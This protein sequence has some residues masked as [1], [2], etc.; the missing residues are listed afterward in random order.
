M[1]DDLSDLDSVDISELKDSNGGGTYPPNTGGQHNS[2]QGERSSH[3]GS[4]GGQ[5]GYGGGQNGGNRGGYNNNQ[6]GGQGGYG[7]GQGGNRSYGGNSGGGYGGGQGGGNRGGY[8]GGQGGFKRKEEEIEEPYVPVAIY[9]DRDFPPEIK[10]ALYN[11]ASK[12]INKKITVRYN[13]DDKD[14]HEK[15]SSLSTKYTEAY[16]AWKG[17]NDVE[18]R[19]SWNTL[20]AKHLA[21]MHSPGWDKIPDVVKAL[22]ARTVRMVFG[23]KNNSI[24]MCVITWSADGASKAAEVT[25]DT[26]RSSFIIKLAATYGFPVLNTAKSG[27]ENVLEKTFGL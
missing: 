18:T 17:F 1:Y 11:I 13:A 7:G 24:A 21:Q 16:A 27:T 4:Q 3:Q 12:L 6:G 14:F 25:K 15:I 5:G 22:L 9:V 20:T 8:G 26:G 19:H 10:T 2:H 23:D